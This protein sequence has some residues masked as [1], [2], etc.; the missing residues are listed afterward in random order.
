MRD[1]VRMNVEIG[2]KTKSVPQVARELGIGYM[3][4][5]REAERLGVSRRM[6]FKADSEVDEFIRKWYGIMR[7][8]EM[9]RR[10]NC[11]KKSVYYRARVLGLNKERAKK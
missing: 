9:A 8:D 4:V 3:K 1:D 10:L 11:D 6:Q 2:L 5:Y 7:A